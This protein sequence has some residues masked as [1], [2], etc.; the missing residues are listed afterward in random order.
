MVSHTQL[1][2]VLG[3]QSL[4][5]PEVHQ[6]SDC[7][8]RAELGSVRLANVLRSEAVAIIPVIPP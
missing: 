3:K 6:T 1:F 2:S 8:T 7:V 4:P 5:Q